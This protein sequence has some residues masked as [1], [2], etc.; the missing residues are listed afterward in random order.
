M[1][2]G[3]RFKEKQG[4]ILSKRFEKFMEEELKKNSDKEV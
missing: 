3:I 1:A 4:L 2:R